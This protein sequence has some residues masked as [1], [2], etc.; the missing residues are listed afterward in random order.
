MRNTDA[1]RKQWRAKSSI[2]A[3][4]T[5]DRPRRPTDQ[6]AFNSTNS[7]TPTAGPSIDAKTS[8]RNDLPAI[9]HNPARLPPV[10][11]AGLQLSS[12]P[13]QS[14]SDYNRDV[15]TPSHFAVNKN[16]HRKN[17]FKSSLPH[18]WHN[19]ISQWRK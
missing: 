3:R 18:L 14:A 5:K 6:N 9:T 7:P 11:S 8:I 2:H 16:L 19:V 17:A 1:R 12:A 4:V 10:S 13:S 15:S